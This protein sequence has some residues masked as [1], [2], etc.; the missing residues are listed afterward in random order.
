VCSPIPQFLTNAMNLFKIAIF[1][2][3]RRINPV[4]SLNKVLFL[5]AST[6][7]RKVDLLKFCS[8]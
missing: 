8:E 5:I 6:A 1:A 2:S 4:R 7:D 3:H